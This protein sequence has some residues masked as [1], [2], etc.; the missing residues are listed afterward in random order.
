MDKTLSQDEVDALLQAV[1]SGEMPDSDEKPSQQQ[2]KP[3]GIKIITYDFRQ[4]NLVSSDQFRGF[5]MIHE[6]FTKAWQAS[7]MTSLRVPLEVKLVSVDTFSYREFV[8][9]LINPT[10]MI[11]LDTVPDVGQMA[12]EIN[13]S[14]S[15]GILDIMLGGDGSGMQ[16]SREL[17]AI[18]QSMIGSVT[19]NLISE[20]KT[21]WAGTAD[22]GFKMR[23]LESDPS[24]LA[25]TTP[26]ASVLNATFDL[27]IR[28]TA[29]TMNICY[30][31]EMI[32][33]ILSRVTARLSGQKEHT[34]KDRRN[35]LAVIGGIPLTMKVE[36]GRGTIS[37]NRLAQLDVGDVICLDR[38]VDGAMDVFVSDKLCYQA[39]LGWRRGK[40]AVKLTQH[41]LANER[42]NWA[43]RFAK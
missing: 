29:G 8:L 34:E 20:L 37:T 13:S 19:D 4:P 16:E 6:T 38:G 41:A 17:T 2:S 26:E 40:I 33:P 7:L 3:E 42:D 12:V 23:L 35:M 32:K 11:S 28:D 14:V 27:R 18:E 1:K 43:D 9:S 15:L 22:F 39:A 36:M 21:A 31:F 5:Q 10:V 25:M 24:R 30:P